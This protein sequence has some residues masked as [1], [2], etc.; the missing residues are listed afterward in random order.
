[1]D[2]NEITS[3]ISIRQ[4]VAN[5][6]GNSTIDRETVR[7]MNNLI[8]LID[9]K[10]IS[11]FKTDEFKDYVNYADVK[12]AVQDAVNVANIKSGLKK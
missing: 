1:M 8:I 5:S 6:T 2:L 9:K 12:Q 3:L 11:M 10:L 7:Y 4:Y